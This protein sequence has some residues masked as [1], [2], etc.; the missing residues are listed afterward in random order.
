MDPPRVPAPLNRLP[1]ELA[2]DQFKPQGAGF[3]G[4]F[5]RLLMFHAKDQI[6]RH[7][8]DSTR[9]SGKVAR[10]REKTRSAV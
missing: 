7:L 10:R 8:H 4:S 1:W 3:L 2:Q 6:V 5:G 9:E